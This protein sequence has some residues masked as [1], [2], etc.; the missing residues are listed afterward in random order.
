MCRPA[1]CFPGGGTRDGVPLVIRPSICYHREMKTEEESGG[2]CPS[3]SSSPIRVDPRGA[4][5]TSGSIL[6][7]PEQ[8]SAQHCPRYCPCRF[9]SSFTVRSRGGQEERVDPSTTPPK[10]AQTLPSANPPS[11]CA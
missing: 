5:P 8:S 11:A 10:A 9:P 1:S 3:T 7:V 2:S 4:H 6:E